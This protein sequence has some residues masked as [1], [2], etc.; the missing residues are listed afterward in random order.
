MVG[1]VDSLDNN[2]KKPNIID[3]NN[4]SFLI[5][6]CGRCNGVDSTDNC[7]S[8]ST[9]D[10]CEKSFTKKALHSPFVFVFSVYK[11]NTKSFIENKIF[12]LQNRAF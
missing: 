4:K 8:S 7:L 11:S 5:I 1:A 6:T 12:A 2:D 9:A 3:Y 10:I